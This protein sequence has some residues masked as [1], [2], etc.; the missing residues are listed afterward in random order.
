MRRSATMRRKRHLHALK[1]LEHDRRAEQLKAAIAASQSRIQ[2]RHEHTPFSTRPERPSR[3]GS[4]GR[5][6]PRQGVEGS[7]ETTF[8]QRPP[9]H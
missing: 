5:A 6:R 8:R 4:P 1:A 3:H 2:D 9:P 7:H